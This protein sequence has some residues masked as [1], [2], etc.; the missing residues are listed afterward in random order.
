WSFVGTSGTPPAGQLDFLSLAEH[1]L[2]HVL[3]IGGSSGWQAD[4]V[5]SN[6][7]FI[8]PH[9]EASYGGPVPLNPSG[10]NGEPADTHWGSSVTSFGQVPA[11]SVNLYYPGQRREFMPLDWAGL[12]DI[13]WHAD[14]LAVTS[15]PPDRVFAGTGFGLAVSV[16]DP[17]GHVDPT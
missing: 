7:T 5:A 6:D 11:M 4:V 15:E 17:D 14:H 1:E 16:E 12:Q 3:G 10:Q 9:A 2:G 13:G 8:G